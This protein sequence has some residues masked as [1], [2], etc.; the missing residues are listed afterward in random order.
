MVRLS[1]TGIVGGEPKLIGATMNVPGR[2]SPTRFVELEAKI[3][4]LPSPARR[5]AC[6]QSFPPEPSAADERRVIAP[7]AAFTAKA[8][9]ASFVSPGTRVVA[10]ERKLT[11]DE[12]PVICASSLRPLDSSPLIAEPR[13]SET[14]RVVPASR[15]WT[16]TSTWSF[17]SAGASGLGQELKATTL[18]SAEMDGPK[19]APKLRGVPQSST[20]TIETAPVTRSYTKT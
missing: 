18:P 3:A 17:R 14:R 20:E 16:K 12:S 11:I 8:S 10:S 9:E 5:A 13:G 7:V 19:L 2:P 15:L 6:V 1:G 4:R